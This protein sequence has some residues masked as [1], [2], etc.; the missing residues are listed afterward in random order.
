M[1]GVPLLHANRKLHSRIFFIV[2]ILLAILC[3]PMIPYKSFWYQ[4][5]LSGGFAMTVAGV[6][7][8][9]YCSLFIGGRKNERVVQEGPFSVVRNPLYLCSLLAI[10]GCA[11]Q[12]GMISFVLLVVVAF[13]LYYPRVVAK[14]EAF[15]A[16]RFGVEYEDYKRKVPRWEVDFSLWHAPEI[17][18][19]KLAFIWKTILDSSLF[20]ITG[21][22]IS[23]VI[24]LHNKKMLMVLMHLP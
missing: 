22:A 10:T 23:L 3:K 1:T 19:I 6:M 18:D 9:V 8:R 21:P 13:A 11:M 5:L 24:F 20:F 16:H 17:V 12:T 7:G 2:V 15:L 4:L 14:E